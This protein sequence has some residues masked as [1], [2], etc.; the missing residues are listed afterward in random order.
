VLLVVA[1]LAV[2]VAAPDPAASRVAAALALA[3]AGLAAWRTARALPG[4]SGRALAAALRTDRPLAVVA[5]TLGLCLLLL[6]A[7]LVAGSGWLA[8][9][10]W[11]LLGA[12]AAFSLVVGLGRRLRPM[13]TL[14]GGDG[15]EPDGVGPAR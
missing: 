14:R 12:A 13:I 5:I 3:A 6:V 1:T 7:V 4:R 8:G 2:L 11:L 15:T 10:I 9:A